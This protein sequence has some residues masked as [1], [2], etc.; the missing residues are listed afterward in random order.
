MTDSKELKKIKCSVKGCKNKS[1]GV[2]EKKECCQY[3]YD[4]LNPKV[5]KF[6]FSLM[7]GYY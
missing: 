3:H 2:F 1:E 7:K 6:R 4:E 5:K